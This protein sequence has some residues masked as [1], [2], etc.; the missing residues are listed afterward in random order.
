MSK[1]FLNIALVSLLWAAAT[2]CSGSD[3]EGRK[4]PSMNSVTVGWIGPLTGSANILGKDNLNAVKLALEEYETHK[5]ATDPT[6]KL[7]IA[8]DKYQEELTVKAYNE[9]IAKHKPVAIFVTTY[10]GVTAIA[11]K[12]LNDSV[13]IID[14]IDNDGKLSQLNHNV[15]LIGK[16]TEGLAG[17]HANAI[18]DQGKKNT[19]VIYFGSDEFMPTVAKTL[20]AILLSNENK[21]KLF[22]YKAGTADFKPFLE[23]GKEHNV[24]SYA[25]FGYKEIAIAMKQAREMGITAPFYTVNLAFEGLNESLGIMEGTYFAHFTSLD[26]NRVKADEFINNYEKTYKKR[27]FLQWTALQAYDAATILFNA[28]K[29]AHH[30]EGDFLDNLRD[31]LLGVTNFEG[32]SGMITILPSGAS[33]GIYPNLYIFKNGQGLRARNIDK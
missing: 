16:E 19:A 27:P 24:D 6:I 28:I 3:E 9:L 13:I 18:I 12:A 7:T 31:E 5:S 8:D 1:F 4:T 30:K 11:G 17:I 15:F 25:F 29:S 10:S 22:E 20:V 21:V 14:P 33:R 23:W 2:G 26:G 32:V